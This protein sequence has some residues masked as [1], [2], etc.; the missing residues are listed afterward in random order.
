MFKKAI[1]I[2]IFILLLSGVAI[3]QSSFLNVLPSWL[4]ALNL[5]LISLIF[6]LFF[7]DYRA[8]LGAALLLGGWLD[9]F[10][11]HFF[12]F[13]I[14]AL[15]LS[16]SAAAL[17]LSSWLTNR[18]LYSFGLL[19]GLAT[20]IY[21]LIIGLLAYFS[22]GGPGFFVTSGRFWLNLFYQVVWSELAA[23]LMFNLASA[24]TRRFQPF[25]LAKR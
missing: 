19:I 22:G 21:N 6:I 13:Y 14:L 9:I 11:F 18:S 24:A 2:L 17:I 3:A 16:L 8:A 20:I 4:G 15:W 5:T 10:S 25:F 23:L 1:Q 7:Y 12:G